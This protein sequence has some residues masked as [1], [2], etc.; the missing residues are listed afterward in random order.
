MPQAT[1]YSKDY[2]LL[3]YG[4]DDD[5]GLLGYPSPGATTAGCE[6]HPLARPEVEKESHCP[7]RTPQLMW[8]SFPPRP[9]PGPEAPARSLQSPLQ[10]PSGALALF[11]EVA[12]PA[13]R[14]P[15]SLFPEV[16]AA[17]R[18]PTL[19]SDSNM[20]A[21]LEGIHCVHPRTALCGAEG[22]DILTLRDHT[23]QIPSN[24]PTYHITSFT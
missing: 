4:A 8:S 7:S 6:H 21:G 12:L 18:H 10:G 3:R 11:S 16:L 2:S 14:P 19:P 13:P 23:P 22:R 17:K 24:E 15:P 20:V 5:Y 1:E 9:Q